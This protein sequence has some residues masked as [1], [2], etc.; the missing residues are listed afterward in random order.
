MVI[1]KHFRIL[2]FSLCVCFVPY[3]NNCFVL[4]DSSLL[5][6]VRVFATPYHLK[7]ACNSVSLL[8]IILFLKY[9]AAVFNFFFHKTKTYCVLRHTCLELCSL[10]PLI[11][12]P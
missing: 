5:M 8:S 6:L 12:L 4:K 1:L 7:I 10:L 3:L 11:Q 2:L 9:L